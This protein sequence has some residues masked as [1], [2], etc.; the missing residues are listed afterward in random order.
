MATSPQA[1]SA[2]PTPAPPPT[3]L[4][5]F[6]VAHIDASDGI[7][8]AAAVYRPA[9]AGPFPALLAASPYRFDND[10]LPPQAPFMFRET[11]PIGLYVAQGYAYVHLDVR[12]TGRSGG[13]FEFLGPNEQ[14]DL[15]EVIAWVAR[16]PWCS[17]KVG[18]IGQSYYCMSQWLM[19]VQQP[20][21]LACLGAYDGMNDPYRSGVYQGGLLTDFFPGSWW[22]QNRFINLNPANGQ[23][24]RMLET[25][26]NRLLLAHPLYDD[27]WRVR[28]AWERLADIT[29]PVYSCGVWVKGHNPGNLAGFERA[30]GPKK[31]RV[32]ALPSAFAAQ[33]EYAS[34]QFHRE[35]MLP[36]YDHYLK[37]LATDYEQRPA[38]EYQVRAGDGAW[39]PAP[40]WPPPG[41]L[42]TTWY[43]QNGPTDSVTSLNDGALAATP[44]AGEAGPTKYAYP[45]AGWAIGVVGFGPQG[46]ASG[47]D[48]ARRILTFTG[49]VLTEDVV[50]TG[51]ATLTLY[52]ASTN[53]DTD[54][55]VKVQ[56][57]FPQDAAGWAQGL[58]PHFENVTKGW[59]RAS[60]RALVAD[61][62][63]AAPRHPHDAAVPLVP[64][65]V[66]ELEIGLEP[67][68]YLFKAGHRIRLDIANGDSALTDPAFTHSYPP[69]SIGTDTFFHD[70]AHPARLV[71]PSRAPG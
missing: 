64:G 58:N 22:Y 27:F 35:V 5:E 45:Q 14:R 44:A 43:L 46:P 65:Q 4:P 60:H 13:E 28:C 2:R 70:A 69:S 49:P 6:T 37:G 30:G 23:H 25:D 57:Q 15:G 10:P 61:P 24:P 39:L 9:G 52:L 16:Q 56:D 7:Q 54:V 66:Y 34:E 71:L 67:M 17:G 48:P 19:G 8:L 53:T 1:P 29:V 12:G 62:D 68:A 36:F 55:V 41:L 40:A 33:A 51:T 3:P 59:L 11:G 32:T 20:P 47:P 31:L 63:P 38:V 26:L 21:A 18:G 42:S 50:L